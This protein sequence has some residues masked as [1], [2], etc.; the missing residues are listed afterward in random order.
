LLE[1]GMSTTHNGFILWVAERGKGQG[2]FR[3][4]FQ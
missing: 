2:G 3:E 4:D 1:I